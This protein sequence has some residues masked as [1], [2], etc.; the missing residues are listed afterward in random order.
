MGAG[1]SDTATLNF[2]FTGASTIRTWDIKASQIACGSEFTPPNG[3][4]QYHTE[5]DGRLTTFNFIPT[6]DNH[7]A[8]Q[9]YSICIRQEE[10]YCCVQYMVCAD[11]NSMSLDGN[12]GANNINNLPFTGTDCV[13][14]YLEIEGSSDTCAQNGNVPLV[15]TFCGTFLNTASGT[16]ASIPICDCTPPFEVGIFT[17]ALTDVLDGSDN[18]IRS[19]GKHE[20]NQTVCLFVYHFHFQVFVWSTRK[21]HATDKDNNNKFVRLFLTHSLR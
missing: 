3:C 1:C 6:N 13:Q 7:L 19:R 9:Q 4:L 21:F 5:L 2:A 14:D 18:T 20:D 11:A 17:D 12:V 16:S 8:N 15:N 10:G